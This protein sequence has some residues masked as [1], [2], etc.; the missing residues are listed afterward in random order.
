MVQFWVEIWLDED[1][2]VDNALRT[3]NYLAYVVALGYLSLADLSV[4]ET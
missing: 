1:A 3:Y 2:A 4:Y